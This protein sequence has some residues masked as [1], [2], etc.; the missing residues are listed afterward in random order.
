MKKLATLA[1]A[2]SLMAGTAF[3]DNPDLIEIKR[4]LKVRNKNLLN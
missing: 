4:F 2:A 1:A 3:A